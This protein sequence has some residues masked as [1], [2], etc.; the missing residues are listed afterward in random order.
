MPYPVSDPQDYDIDQQPYKIHK[1]SLVSLPRRR[2]GP[3]GT[4]IY[5]LKQEFVN[6]VESES[7]KRDD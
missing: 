3:L 1:D 4:K 6:T 5:G 2:S 7:L